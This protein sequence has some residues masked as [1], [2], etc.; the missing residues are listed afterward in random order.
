[1]KIGKLIPCLVIPVLLLSLVAPH[2]VQAWSL[3]AA[4]SKSRQAA[5]APSVIDI[6]F[7]DRNDVLLSISN[8]GQIGNEL[9]S[10]DGAGYFPGDSENNYVYGTGL[11][12]GAIYDAD[13]DGV[14]DTVWTVA[15]DPLSGGSEFR[16]G[17]SDQDPDDPGTRVFESTNPID[18]E[19]WPS[20]FSDPAGEPIVCSDEDLVTSYTTQGSNPIFGVANMPLE[21]HQ[22]S[23]AFAEPDTIDQVIFFVFRAINTG[24]KILE[25]AWVGFDSDMD[26]GDL[27]LDDMTSLIEDVVEPGGDTITLHMGI[28][29]DSDFEEISFTS[30]PGLVGVLPLLS[31]GNPHDGVDND[32]DGLVDES[33][34]NGLDDDGDGTTDEWD[35]VDEIGFTNFS[36][37]SNPSVDTLRS[38][39]ESDPEGYRLTSCT[40]P[41]ECVELT[42]PSDIRFMISSGSFDWHPGEVQRIVLAFVFANAVGEPDHLEL[43]GDPPRPDPADP[44]L[45]EL[46]RAALLARGLLDDFMEC[47]VPVGIEEDPGPDA[48]PLPRDFALSQNYPNP[49]NPTTTLEATVPE[50]GGGAVSLVILDVRGRKVRTL[51]EGMLPPGRHTFTWDGRDDKGLPVGSGLYFYTLKVGER[52]ATKKMIMAR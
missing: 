23:L 24:E 49:F 35:E 34:S 25:D 32:S 27:Y 10:G 17:R 50:T 42:D 2:A 33:P 4:A 14:N 18:L 1:M 40:P 52:S 5:V 29:W 16:E 22:R 45:G 12:F 19:E 13:E 38:D 47:S 8:S 3:L 15:Y 41:E 31:P 51:L 48:V 20:Q 26:V 7:H 43:V 46:V 37:H 11:W 28:A 9:T 44:T 39:P 36:Y 30:H 21:I 6:A